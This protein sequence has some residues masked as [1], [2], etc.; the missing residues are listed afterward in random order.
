M[1]EPVIHLAKLKEPFPPDRISWRVGSTTKDKSKGMALAYIDAR[2]VMQ[3][4]DDVCGPENW[5]C[6]YPHA[7]QKTVCRI[8]I[9]INGEWVWK[10]N[11][12]GDSDI[13]AEKGALSDA[14]KRAAVLWGIGQYLYDL[15][16]PWVALDTQTGSDG[17]V[18]VKGIAKQEYAK[19][20]LLVGGTNSNRLKKDD[21]WTYFQN[22][23][24]GCGTVL[25]VENLYR[26]LRKE[27]WPSAWLEQAA[28]KCG[29]RKQQIIEAA[30]DEER[31]A[32]PIKDT[33]AASLKH[34]PVGAM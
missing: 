1:T 17:K 8:G 28:E 22:D 9:R 16:S 5:Q 25:A 15:D 11:G 31:A 27:G 23:L 2:D 34:H 29:E 19:L 26:A 12:A 24:L 14:F 33:L 13:E 3:R 6:D 20:H 7:A 30:S 10:S 18:Y 21:A 32:M 4:L